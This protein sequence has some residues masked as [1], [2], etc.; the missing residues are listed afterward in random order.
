MFG[1]NLPL[2]RNYILPPIVLSVIAIL[3]MALDLRDMLEFH[4][5][6]V[7]EGEFW[8]ILSSQYIHTN[9]THLGL[10]LIGIL[11][12]WILH[13]EH[14]STSRYF[15]HIILLGIWTGVGIWLFCPDIKVY[16]GLSGLLHGIIV[17]GALKDIQ[18]K[19]PTGVL[20]FLGIAGKLAWEQY[21]GPSAEV[22]N[23]INSRVAIESHLIGAIGGVVLA[24][25][26]FKEKFGLAKN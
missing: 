21:A 18:T 4:R 26:L 14:T 16:T 22:G 5:Q 8:R 3:L 23:L 12:I 7:S 9:W 10:N 19:E 13:A 24:I 11:F 2:S 6:L 17:W 15:T 20:L 1:L 25:P